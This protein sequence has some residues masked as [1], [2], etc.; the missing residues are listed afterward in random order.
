MTLLYTRCIFEAFRRNFWMSNMM[1]KTVT[2]CWSMLQEKRVSC[3][4]LRWD[5]KVLMHGVYQVQQRTILL[6]SVL[7]DVMRINKKLKISRESFQR[8]ERRA[9]SRK[10]ILF[11]RDIESSNP[12]LKNHSGNRTE[13]RWITYRRAIANTQ[14]AAENDPN[15]VSTVFVPKNSNRWLL[16]NQKMLMD[17]QEKMKLSE[18]RSFVPESAMKKSKQGSAEKSVREEDTPSSDASD[19]VARDVWK[20]SHAHGWLS[21]VLRLLL[22]HKSCVETIR[23]S[24]VAER[25]SKTKK[26]RSRVVK[27]DVV[28]E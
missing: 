6:L 23:E 2:V 17:I 8:H 21:W 28:S 5:N 12:I 10:K 13:N 19:H 27:D 14:A 9:C 15:E 24:P 25:F 3:R 1:R 20:T 18:D 26:N 7:A 4:V 16:R 22:K 11:F